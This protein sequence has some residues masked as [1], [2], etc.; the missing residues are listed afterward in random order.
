[1]DQTHLQNNKYEP[2]A[3][4]TTNTGCRK[5]IQTVEKATHE[6][7][8][9]NVWSAVKNARRTCAMWY[10][11]SAARCTVGSLPYGPDQ[12]VP[13]SSLLD[14]SWQLVCDM[15][16]S[17]SSVVPGFQLLPRLGDNYS[18]FQ[19]QKL[20]RSHPHAKLSSYR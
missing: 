1:M 2:C 15:D 20:D 16:S 18:P 3:R 5:G 13:A 10:F 9:T 14:D 12:S 4:K 19:F 11:R 7:R 17:E 6:S 8:R